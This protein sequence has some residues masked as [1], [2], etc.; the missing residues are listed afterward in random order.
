VPLDVELIETLMGDVCL[1]ASLAARQ[2]IIGLGLQYVTTSELFRMWTN[3]LKRHRPS[4]RGPFGE[5]LI[6]RVRF[7]DYF[8]VAMAHFC[9]MSAEDRTRVR[10]AIYPLA[11]AFALGGVETQFLATFSALE[12]LNVIGLIGVRA[13]RVVLDEDRW[14]EIKRLVKQL[15]K[16]LGAEYT[17]DEKDALCQKIGE[18]NRPSARSAFEQFFERFKI[19]AEDLWPLFGSAELPGLADIR[20]RLAHGETAPPDGTGA[21]AVALAHAEILLERCLLSVLGYPVAQSRASPAAARLDMVSD[22]RET[23]ALQRSLGA[24]RSCD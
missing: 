3:P 14:P 5:G 19:D 18:L 12:S 4:P 16:G 11:P 9:S 13:A 22:R 15:I 7:E 6:D 23:E 24:E 1:L 2:R 17:K 8:A 10:S 21:L 20:N